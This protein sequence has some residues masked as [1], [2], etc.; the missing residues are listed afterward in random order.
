MFREREASSVSVLRVL[1]GGRGARGSASPSRLLRW[2]QLNAC[3]GRAEDGSRFS[4]LCAAR[5]CARALPCARYVR[6]R[7]QCHCFCPLPSVFDRAFCSRRAARGV[8]GTALT[9]AWIGSWGFLPHKP[10]DF[11]KTRLEFPKFGG[12]R[13]AKRCARTRERG[14]AVLHTPTTQHYTDSIA[15]AP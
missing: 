7:S 1:R 11:Q 15:A 3:V 2:G 10:R 14:N 12:A 5:D 6:C 13:V 8:R 4:D 9:S